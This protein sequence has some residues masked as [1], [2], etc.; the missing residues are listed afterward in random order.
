MFQAFT[1]NSVP[2]RL[3][4]IVAGGIG[5]NL[6]SRDLLEATSL[7]DA[8]DRICSC[9]VAVGHSYNLVDVRSRRIL[10][11]ETASKNR[12]S[13]REVGKKPFFH[14]NMYLHL[15]VEQVHSE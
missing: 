8:L 4:E 15:Q 2:P 1:L 9:N 11:V 14:A 5:R 6:I 12:F 3:E 13:I 7:E 10:N